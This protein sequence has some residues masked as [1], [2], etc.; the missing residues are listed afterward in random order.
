MRARLLFV[1]CALSCLLAL[2]AA[3][4]TYDTPGDFGAL[5]LEPY[6]GDLGGYAY[7]RVIQYVLDQS[8][9]VTIET[10]DYSLGSY[11]GNSQVTVQTFL[12]NLQ[13]GYGIWLIST[14]GSTQGLAIQ[15]YPISQ[16]AQRDADLIALNSSGIGQAGDFY[17][18]TTPSGNGCAIGVSS[19]FIK[20]KYLN[21]GSIIINGSCQGHYWTNSWPSARAVLDYNA[22]PLNITVKADAETVF[23]RMDGLRRYDQRSLADA[24]LGTAYSFNPTTNFNT[25]LSP[26]VRNCTLAPNAAIAKTTPVSVTFDCPMDFTTAYGS[27]VA[28]GG[29]AVNGTDLEWTGDDILKFCVGPWTKG[30]GQ[31]VLQSFDVN[32]GQFDGLRGTHGL[33]LDG[34]GRGPSRDDFIVSVTVAV[35]NP[36]ASL[37][38]F[39]AVRQRGGAHVSWR[40]ESQSGTN[41][42][43]LFRSSALLGPWSYVATVP[44]DS[45]QWDYAVDDVG[46]TSAVY[47]LREVENQGDTLN[48][49]NAELRDQFVLPAEPP[50]TQQ[51]ADSL[52]QSYWNGSTQSMVQPASSLPV[53]DITYV[54]PVD[55]TGAWNNALQPLVND[56]TNKGYLVN[57]ITM[58]QV[59]NTRDGLHNYITLAHQY[60][61]RG[62]TL[63]ASDED[64]RSWNKYPWINGWVQ[65]TW[66]GNPQWALIPMYDWPD[67]IGVQSIS[68][69]WFRP[70]MTSD[71]PY[72]D[73][74]GDS[75]PEI[76][77]TRIPVTT[78]SGLS[79]AVAKILAFERQDLSHGSY[80]VADQGRSYN[81]ESGAWASAMADTF[82]AMIPSSL[83]K[84]R[85]HDTDAAPLTHPQ[86]L[87]Q[88]LSACATQHVVA[89]TFTGTVYN[90]N[91]YNWLDRTQ[92]DSWSSLGTGQF[93]SAIAAPSCE[94]AGTD[95][96]VDPTYGLGLA[97]TSFSSFPNQGPAWIWASNNGSHQGPNSD[98]GKNFFHYA[99]ETGAWSGAAAV[100]LAVRDA[101]RNWFTKYQ[102]LGT[103]ILGDVCS[104]FPGMTIRTTDVVRGTTNGL[105]LAINRNP[106]RGLAHIS[107][108][109]P[110]AQVVDLSIYDLQG[111]RLTA[112]LQ[113]QQQAGHHELSWNGTADGVRL[114]AGM[115]FLHLSCPAGGVTQKVTVLH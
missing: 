34:N 40:P 105:Q 58:D 6:A 33:P 71:M 107:L 86:A 44:A 61:L 112:L 65:Q 26:T 39:T 20:R 13:Q 5:W 77:V 96:R 100:A 28:T 92:G 24:Y 109:L 27:V 9:A 88:F 36:A 93:L 110:S 111:R 54:L 11:P 4:Q 47:E 101:G 12:N 29:L 22:C 114:A 82:A 72:G 14:H 95:R 64:S 102:A 80:L 66:P 46:I 10:Y 19:A 81:G 42:Y 53:Y 68:V 78:P 103:E 84:I 85:L 7:N 115:Y 49:G 45:T 73:V 48:L 23:V 50:A 52:N 91:K 15:T 57:I 94:I 43:L 16:Q 17:A 83:P 18:S 104:P 74:T 56:R 69:S 113:G 89:A 55:P 106:V 108:V 76:P 97:S 21:L 75:I 62:V 37:S 63:C 8:Y 2:P 3:A 35:D 30:T 38:A 79:V 51:M 60:G 99:Y 70:G 87:S 59:G 67:P 1:V 98:M 41:R 32:R 90:R 25:V 31:L